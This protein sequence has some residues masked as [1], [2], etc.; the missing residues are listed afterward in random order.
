[1]NDPNPSF[2][3]IENSRACR[4]AFV[5]LIESSR[6]R[7]I[8][9]APCMLNEL[10]ND[11]LMV[12]SVIQQLVTHR[13][14][15]AKW[16]LPPLTHWRRQCPQLIAAQERLSSKWAWRVLAEN[17][18]RERPQFNLLFCISD[19][20]HA[21]VLGEP[22]RLI[23]YLAMNDPGIT[24]PLTTFFSEIWEKSVADGELRRLHI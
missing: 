8:L 3:K 21:W 12:D 18:P 16:I 22:Q 2:Q 17:E 7:L 5:Q 6:Q 13:K 4:D 15:Q 11:E 10:F 19:N 1:M 20:R 23:G 14:L 9:Y 24:Q